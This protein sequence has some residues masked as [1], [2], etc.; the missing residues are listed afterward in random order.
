MREYRNS[1]FSRTIM[2]RTVVQDSA[3][4]DQGLVVAVQALVFTAKAI[5]AVLINNLAKEINNSSLLIRG[6][7][8]N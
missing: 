3:L 6:I 1:N 8:S 2:A 4:M 7:Q 5:K